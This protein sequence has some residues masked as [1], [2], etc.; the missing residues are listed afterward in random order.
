MAHAYSHGTQA[1][2]PGTHQSALNT[3]DVCNDCLNF[4]PLLAAA[5]TPGGMPLV[6]PQGRGVDFSWA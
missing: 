6:E 3:H 1:A 5:G 4:A 2:P